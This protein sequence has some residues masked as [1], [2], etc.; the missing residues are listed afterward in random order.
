[1]T[2]FD[3]EVPSGSWFDLKGGGRVQVRTMDA[4]TRK[5][6][7]KQTTKQRVEYKR[8]DGRAERFE[9]DVLDEDLQNALFWDH[10]IV[11]WENLFDAKQVA[12]PCTRDNKIL[13]LSRSSKFVDFVGECLKR[14]AEDE[15]QQAEALEKN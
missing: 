15:L 6:I 14:L 12:I 3:L 8:V 5:A 10:V 11:A 2:I 4:D 7:R 9:V 13:L 1:M